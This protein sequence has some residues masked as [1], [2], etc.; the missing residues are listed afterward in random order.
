MP[1]TKHQQ[2]IDAVEARFQT[3]LTDNGYF[4][5]LG[6][7]VYVWKT[8]PV[9]EDE[10][11]CILIY[12]KGLKPIEENAPIG[13]FRWGLDI[14]VEVFISSGETSDSDVRKALFDINR[15]IFLNNGFRWGGLAVRTEQP[16]IDRETKQQER[17]IAG[18]MISFR[19]IYDASKGET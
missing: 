8:S 4:L 7:K 13:Y 6:Q 3:I 14:D 18:A 19:I 15:A 1:D 17:I 16:S 11:P 9:Q 5:N 2:I 10:R 12:D